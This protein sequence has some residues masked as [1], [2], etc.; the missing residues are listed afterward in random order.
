MNHIYGLRWNR[1]LAQWIV[2]SE[3]SRRATRGHG[4]SK[5]HAVT[6]R[7]A[8]TVIALGLSLSYAWTAAA[9]PAGGKITTG[10]GQITQSGTTTTVQQNSQ[11]LSL[12]WQSFD[13][14]T[15]ETVNFVQPNANALAVNRIFSASASEILGH[16]NSNGQVWLIN[17]NGVLFGEH[18]QVNVG[19]LVASTLDTADSE[20][21]DTRKFS[22]ISSGS[23]INQ[24][25]ITAASGGYVAL[26][27]H[28]VSNQGVISAQL[29]T[30]ALS[31]GS[32]QT[33]TFTGNH[34]LHV[35]VD[36][37]QLNDLVENR[38]LIQA[39]GGQVFMTAGAK[40]AV[41]A[42]VVNNTGVV[43]AQ[44]VE[45]HGGKIVLLGGGAST[46]NVGGTL[47]A[48][49]PHGG[50]GG[51][52]ETSGAKVNI[53]TDANITAAAPAG[54]AGT[55]LVD[56]DDLTIDAAAATTIG[57]SLNSGTSVTEVTTATTATGA[58]Q[59]APGVGDINVTAAI[60]WTNPTATLTLDAYHGINVSAP[61]S[62]AGQLVMAA[63]SGNL[64]L[65]SAVSGQA[66]VTLSTASGN[67][68]NHAGASAVSTGSNA[69][70]LVYSTNP[71]LDTTGG[72]APG[73]IQYD[74]PANTAPIPSTGSGFLY[75]V[76]PT[77]TVTAL[78]GTVTKTYD[79]TTAATV[80]GS[81]MTV[82]GLLNGDSVTSIAGTYGSSD[83]GTGINVTSSTDATT[84]VV[85]NG[86]IPVYGYGLSGP[87]V[88]AAV[89]TI[90]PKTITASI[91]G[92]PTKTYD[93]TTT[94]TLD[95]G[96]YSFS[97][98]ISGQGATVSQ[99][100]SVAYAA[101]DA[102][103]SALVNAT[104]TSTNFT[105]G[106]GTNLANYILPTT[107]TGAGI[108][109]PAPVNLTGLLATS[110]T[111][112]GTNL[113]SLNTSNA[114]IFG[115]IA[116]DAGS[117]SLNA[118]GAAATFAQSNVGNNIAVT[119]TS[120][121]FQLIGA[122]ASDY[123]LIAPGDL[124]ANISPKAL[125]VGNV[126]GTN[127]VYDGNTADGLNFSQATLGGVL[128]QDSGNVALS[129][130]GATGTFA[131]PNAASGIAV[132]V[133]GVQLSG[134][135]AG[136]YSI[137]QPTGVTANITPAPLSITLGGSQAKPYNGTTTATVAGS[138]FTITGFIGTENATITQNA[139]AQYS[140]PN[141]GSNIPV[142][143]TL[144]A[145]DFTT[146]SGTLIS[147]YSFPH[148]VT[149]NTGTIN[150]IP[151]SAYINNNPTKT[152]DGTTTATVTSG[153]YVLTG[154]VG[155][156]SASI[157]QPNASYAAANA[158]PETVTAAVTAAN[159]TAGGGTL[160]SNYILPTTIS[161][162]GTIQPAQLTGN[163]IN[164]SIV[165]NPT[166]TYDG[167]T[168]ATLAPS[169]FQLTGF[170]NGDGATVT[171][172]AGQYSSANVGTQSVTAQLTSG[173]FA[174]N[175][176]TTLSNYVLPTVVYGSGTINPAQLTV[177]IVGNP[178]K[179]Y[180]GSTVTS[181]SPSNYS[182][183]G[184]V[185]GQG[186]TITPSSLI[187]YDGKDVGTHTITAALT[188]SA[189]TPDSGTLMSNYTLATSA[190]GTGQITPAPLYVI[191]VAA[192]N[193]QY[194]STTAAT[195]NVSNAGLGGLVTGES[196][197]VTLNTTTGGTFAQADVAN[198]IAV[199]TSGFSISG[200]GAS[201]YALQ[202]VTGLHANITPAPLTI[203][204]VTA[205]DKSYDGTATATL[206][207]GAAV[208]QG[209]FNSDNVTLDSSGATGAFASLNAGAN[210]PVTAS[211]FALGGAKAFDYSLSQP[212]G[213][214]ATINQAQIT[215]TI[216]GNPTKEY[217]GS[218]SATLTSA[219]YQLA[220][221]VS[222]QGATVPQ[223]ATANYL[224]ANAG[225]NVGLESTLVISDFVPNAGTNLANYLM[226]S[227][228]MGT[229]G[230]ITPKVLNLTGT[231]VYDT[232]TD[233]NSTLFG[234]LTG[235]NGDTFTVS[236]T[237]TLVSK[238]VGT[239]T[240]T[241]LGTLTLN[242]G[243]SGTLASNYTLQGGTDWVNITPVTLTVTGTTGSTKVYDGNTSAAISGATLNGVL[244]S[245][246]VSLN[247][248]TSGNF[249][250]KN[251]GAGKTIT[252]AMT[253]G[254]SD[255]G[256]YVLTQPNSVTGGIT[257]DHITVTAAGHNKQYDATLNDTVTLSST[258]IING[259][260]VSFT[261]TSA[262]FGDPNVGIG[263]TVTVT[264]IAPAGAD[265]GNYIV[266]VTTVQTTADINPRVLNLTGTRVYD[267]TTNANASLFG[268]NGTLTGVA[269]QTLTL[270]GTGTLTSKDVNNQQ[271]FPNLNGFALQDGTGLASN[272]T[273]SGGTDW[274]KITPAPLTVGNTVVAAKT[275]DGTTN[276]SLSGA[277]L[278]GVLATDSVSLGNDTTGTFADKNVGTGKT[279]TT[280]MTLS[281]QDA[282]DYRLT[283]P[284][285]TGNISTKIISVNATGIDKTYDGTLNAG[286][287]I[288]SPDIASGDSVTFADTS[289]LFQSKNVGTGIGIAVTGISA[290]G[291]D[292]AN[293]TLSA[294]SAATS[295]NINPAIINLSGTRIYDASTDANAALF[296]SGGVL[297]TGVNGETLTL[298]GSG[299]LNS[300][301]VGSQGFQ[302]LGTLALGDST[303]AAGNYTLVGGTDTVTVTPSHITVAANGANKVYDGNT[304][305]PGLTLTS[306]GVFAGDQVSFSDTSADFTDKNV[307]TNKPIQVQGIAITGGADA[308]N[309]I[310]D[311]TT[312][313]T[314][315]NIT[316][317]P[318]AVTASG[319]NKIYDATTGD[320]V[321]LASSQILPGDDI[322]FSTA[323]ALFSDKNVGTGKAVAVSGITASGSD[324]GNYS[325]NTTAA[326]SANITPAPLTVIN[327]LALNKTYD[328]TSAAAVTG[329]TLNG[330]L[331]SDAVSLGNSTSG[332]FSDPNAGSGKGVTTAMTLTGTDASNYTLT[333]PSGL[334]ANI[335]PAILNLTGSR[336]YDGTTNAVASLFG[337]GGIIDGVNGETLTLSGTGALSSRNVSPAQTFASLN[338]FN[339]AGNNG[340]LASNYTL[341]GGV[342]WV[343]ITPAPLVVL[344]TQANDKVYDGNTDAA[345]TGATLSGVL[346]TDSVTLGNDTTGAFADKNVGT[347]K[348]VTTAM[349]LSG[350]DAD[351][352]TL[353]Q[354]G[355]LEADVTPKTITV[356]ATG[357]NKVYDGKA[358]DKVTL[359][360]DG[361]VSGDSV[362]LTST[363]ATFSN[364]NVG[365]DKTVTVNGLKLAGA[366]A[367]DY[368]LASNTVTTT[369][370]ITVGT[371]IQDT[372]V[373]VAYLDLSPTA[374][375]TPYG[376]APADS[377]GQLTGNKK[378]L[379][380]PVEAN[381]VRTDFESGLSLR[382]VEGG[383]R[384]PAP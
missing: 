145:S 19:G 157:S 26:L 77:V 27:G 360:S 344:N 102:S 314:T 63:G 324:A 224:T 204:Q 290:G 362:T 54:R 347:G 276:A 312:T 99:P 101:P 354:P 12:N 121:S 107:A 125:T 22:G 381:E 87:S 161:G 134:S 48:T 248:D 43:Q 7:P 380:R 306:S 128:P 79:G 149:G 255:A 83:A 361:I 345:L 244:G 41:L 266:D 372:A 15:Q 217:D 331:G 309:Y 138:D 100:S 111:Y 291:T 182:V 308:G 326:T 228:A 38:Q 103:Q 150:P 304:S 47:D 25:T 365:N 305:D 40:N 378:L 240:F 269:G 258:G 108:I 133:S 166:K 302:S 151:L 142:T 62:G 8:L 51:S 110:K 6:R 59:S 89:G 340:A 158:G 349:T 170:V 272:Y 263:K 148:T 122:K 56:P 198:G 337:N 2:T 96:N 310:V 174:P 64:T 342:D 206:S 129:T 246:S 229:G 196:G 117:V 53:E 293:Y 127:K 36:A 271:T 178:T 369:A 147:N 95:S 286:V 213:L 186:A 177:S 97:G 180:D 20:G 328:G 71:G 140:T 307:Q 214:S 278:Q 205:N 185:A 209:I 282:G 136:N 172:T 330:V 315:A 21:S 268:N 194:D 216:I 351:N 154:F 234:T 299:N 226:P 297:S 164:G 346:G 11:T 30:V 289:A 81:N 356:M 139:Q 300:K 144:E 325:F 118:S 116:P 231:R 359:A 211:G 120:G 252:T 195:L 39:D 123:T 368:A 274:V 78:S 184:F 259:D 294:T 35:Q 135:A 68:V 247:N 86:A 42:S 119:V 188:A 192:N 343:S 384:M 332:V 130:A 14:G 371:G 311:N 82:T 319:T 189:Y 355:G 131:S 69:R 113:A 45:N 13:V 28:Q 283:Q 245:D 65:N 66:G 143:A 160:L 183:A 24:G 34:L 169:N 223:S 254:G 261:D 212:T 171:Q 238:N 46:V 303:G 115:I 109:N 239:E 159:Y 208:L 316:A 76:A 285:L 85:A 256:N 270:T 106:S 18:A 275:Y 225:T 153:D 155:G 167:T 74:A 202:P 137:G 220:G 262:L 17:P 366:D 187:N 215:A 98:F 163:Y 52:I 222:G 353:T 376:V 218:N 73:F 219:N 336:Q 162:A 301:N 173:D 373:A 93:G 260:S 67:F 60:S 364:A 317:R 141:A 236:G 235:L 221:F 298:T 61:I 329:A 132:S 230:T 199:S 237:G 288:T 32:A 320:T 296:T 281:G 16:I 383:V 114:G 58:G 197:L 284:T 313:S 257:A 339:L 152:Y 350:A 92:T 31:A 295:A 321:A 179:V 279:V 10:S 9:G 233:G 322:T 375:A 203:Q 273:L 358:G 382:V 251:V 165:N 112:D 348:S 146:G 292:G 243:G 338:G 241:S 318:I 280:A 191:G 75:S 374:I 84:L 201:N 49:A 88:T 1:S 44:T 105:P 379:H 29:G 70:W 323:S 334:T 277:T 33:L 352:Y 94:A 357:T 370:D 156:E 335:S 124:T 367:G 265:G 287:T 176:G 200:S 181:L 126:A 80:P 5:R 72:L 23:V 55:W 50:N 193:K 242:A 253:L 250:D 227:S 168:V 175:A 57:Q 91:V 104:F 377:P 3:L 333:Q 341:A 190:T 264:G 210:I 4:T 267:A 90:A 327:T 363:S 207:T 37:S 232:T 249:A